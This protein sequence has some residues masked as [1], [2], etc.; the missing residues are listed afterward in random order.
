MTVE[1]YDKDGNPISFGQW[2]DLSNQEG[3]RRVNWDEIGGVRIST[4]WLGLDHSWSA[5]GPPVIFETMIFGGPH[6]EYQ[7]RYTT[8]EAAKKGHALAVQLVLDSQE[9]RE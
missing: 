9:T 2:V 4:V 8:L 3:Y 5:S 7:E 1:H 6:D